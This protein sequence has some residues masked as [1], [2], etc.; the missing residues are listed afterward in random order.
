VQ[1]RGGKPGHVGVSRERQAPDSV[2][3]CRAEV[4]LSCGADLSGLDGEWVGSHQVIEIPQVKPSVIELRL[5]RTRCGCGACAERQY[6][7]G[8]ADAQQDFGPGVHVLIS[9]LNGTH[10][11]AQ[12]RLQQLLSEVWGLQI[13]A[14][15]IA[16]SLQRTAARLE[17]PA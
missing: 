10:H 7:V 6:P 5:Y 15:A 4:C 3:E 12:E 13:S 11:I 2:V 17:Q 16:N 1:R 9:Y 8:Y 14:G